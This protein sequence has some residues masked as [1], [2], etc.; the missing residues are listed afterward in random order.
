M[1]AILLIEDDETMNEMLSEVLESRGYHVT[2]TYNGNEALKLLNTE[3]FD[4]ILTDMLMPD[5][6]GVETIMEIK[7]LSAS[8]PVIAMSGGGKLGPDTYL[9]MARKLGADYA[10][11][12]PFEKNV[13]LDKIAELCV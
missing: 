2:R 9:E 4:L 10:L 12:K 11:Q 5:K 3:S 7:N 1:A 8:T 6:E 13:L